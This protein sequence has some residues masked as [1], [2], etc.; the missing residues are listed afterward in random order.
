MGRSLPFLAAALAGA[1]AFA[2]MAAPAAEVVAVL[3]IAQPG[4]EA[5]SALR[6]ATAVLL[7]GL[8]T[9]G[10]TVKAVPAMNHFAAVT[11]APTL[12]A[13]LGAVGILIPETRTEQRLRARNPATAPGTD[14]ATHVELRLERIGCDGTL[15]WLA[16]ANADKD[17]DR[18]HAQSALADALRQ[19]IADAVESYAAHGDIPGEPVPLVT[20]PP[21]P[22]GTRTAVVPFAQP[23]TTDATLDFATAT[24]LKTLRAAGIEAFEAEPLDALD[25]VRLAPTVCA[26]D[27]ANRILIG[28]VRTRQA[29]RASGF[30]THAEVFLTSVGCDGTVSA[31]TDLTADS[32]HDGTNF[33]AGVND[34]I[35]DAF[36]RWKPAR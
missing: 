36:R 9:A 4:T 24:A 3:P 32:L 26:Q 33:S 21:G 25:I 2:P 35:A 10:D 30:A 15:R 12:C 19:A 18:N 22:R 20:P 11:A 6:D 1:L 16:V 7:A 28:T 8:A 34:A 27:G 31:T 17:D 13:R 29:Q 14:L 23:Q 5:D